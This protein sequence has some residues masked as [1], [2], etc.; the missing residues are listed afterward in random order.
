MASEYRNI[1]DVCGKET[2]GFASCDWA[3][4]GYVELAKNNWDVRIYSHW[5]EGVK[6][7]DLMEL[8]T[9]NEVSLDACLE[10]VLRLGVAIRGEVEKI[11]HERGKP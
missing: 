3:D 11:K 8:Q 1:C 10:C 6:D 9:K 4:P 5:L 7:S 2:K